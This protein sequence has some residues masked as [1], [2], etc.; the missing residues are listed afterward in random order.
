MHA[1]VYQNLILETTYLHYQF[2]GQEFRSSAQD[3]TIWQS[4]GLAVF[5]YFFLKLEIL[6]QTH[7]IVD[8]IHFLA[9]ISTES[10]TG[11]SQLLEVLRSLQCGLHTGCPQRSHSLLQSQ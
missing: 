6:F 11:G 3:L 4:V 5:F 8:R 10:P 1:T 7:M 9:V 2:S